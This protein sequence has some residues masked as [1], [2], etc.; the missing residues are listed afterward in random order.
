MIDVA[1]IAIRRVNNLPDADRNR[2]L[3]AVFS[4]LDDVELPE[5]IHP[6][7]L[8]AVEEGLRQADAGMFASD[9]E[10]EAIF[11]RFVK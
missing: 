8:A 3:N 5:Q 2:I 6:N 1:E 9:E 7:D 10:V 11:A 4:M